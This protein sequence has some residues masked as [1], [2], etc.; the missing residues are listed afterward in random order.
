MGTTSELKRKIHYLD[1]EDDY[2]NRYLNVNSDIEPV[3]KT[4]CKQEGGYI[5]KEEARHF[6][7]L[8]FSNILISQLENIIYQDDQNVK[9]YINIVFS[10]GV[11][12][13]KYLKKT[14]ESDIRSMTLRGEELNLYFPS[15]AEKDTSIAFYKGANYL[16]KLPD[17][18]NIMITRDNYM[19]FGKENLSYFYV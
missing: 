15:D 16:T 13:T 2:I 12:N 1:F 3:E 6:R 18:E 17:L 4:I 11:L 14:L 9:K 7:Q 10:G 19:D 5:N 8:S